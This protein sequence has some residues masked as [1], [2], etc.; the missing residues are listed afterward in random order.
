MRYY[1]VMRRTFRCAESEKIYNRNH[2]RKL[3]QIIQRTAMRKLWLLDAAVELNELRIPPNNR[4]AAC[5]F[6]WY[7]GP[8]LDE[9]SE[10]F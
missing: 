9:S 2:S 3:L 7:I 10:S 8:V 5:P 6:F 1:L 4:L